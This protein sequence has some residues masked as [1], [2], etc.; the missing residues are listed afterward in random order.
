MND[1]FIRKPGWYVVYTV[2]VLNSKEYKEHWAGPYTFE[3][4]G[5]ERDDIAGYEGVVFLRLE[6]VA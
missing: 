5:F 2:P 3:R 6:Q 1:G 4:V